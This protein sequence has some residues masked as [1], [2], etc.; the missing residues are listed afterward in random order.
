MHEV[1][2][3]GGQELAQARGSSADADVQAA[4]G[5]LGYLEGFG[6][7]AGI[8]RLAGVAGGLPRCDWADGVSEQ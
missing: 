3:A 1:D 8:S 2:Q 6:A 7:S 4:G 5:L